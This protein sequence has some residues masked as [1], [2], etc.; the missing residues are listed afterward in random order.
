MMIRVNGTYHCQATCSYS[1]AL[2]SHVK[3]QHF[4][5]DRHYCVD[6][7][8]GRD[9]VHLVKQHMDE[10]HGYGKTFVC[11][12]E[13]CDK[14]FASNAHFNRHVMV[15]QATGKL[16]KCKS[17]PKCYMR[18]EALSDHLKDVH[19]REKSKYMQHVQHVRD[20]LTATRI[21]TH[22]EVKWS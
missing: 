3:R 10:K 22:Q 20:Y 9:S 6:C 21:T 5:E 14:K 7:N 2:K 19:T 1:K 12:K 15:C 17:C 8:F 16:F 13:N 18:K 4:Y 11:T